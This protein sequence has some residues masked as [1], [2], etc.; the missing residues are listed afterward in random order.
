[1]ANAGAAALAVLDERGADVVVT[2]WKMPDMDGLAF[3]RA[4]HERRPGLPSSS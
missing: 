4:A 1:V 3:M 2:D